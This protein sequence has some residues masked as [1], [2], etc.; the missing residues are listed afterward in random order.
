M[1][2]Y[3]QDLSRHGIQFV[4]HFKSYLGILRPKSVTGRLSRHHLFAV[5]DN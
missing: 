2:I 4:H 3:R 1:G 5:K